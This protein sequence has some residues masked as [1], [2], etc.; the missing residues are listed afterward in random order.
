MS[1]A[2]MSRVV[3]LFRKPVIVELGNYNQNRNEYLEFFE[4]SFRGIYRIGNR[5]PAERMSIENDLYPNLPGFHI[6]VDC[7]RRRITVYDPLTRSQHSDTRAAL[8]HALGNNYGCFV[9]KRRF[10]PLNDIVLDDVPVSRMCECLSEL[11]KLVEAGNA[12]PVQGKIPSYI[13]RLVANR[14]KAD[15]EHQWGSTVPTCV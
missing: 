2:L 9:P 3:D 7:W 15:M 4:T 11:H 6:E 8:E 5:S 1:L 14:R 13:R 12:Q 10:N